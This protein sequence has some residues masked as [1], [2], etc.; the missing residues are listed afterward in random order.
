VCRASYS[1]RQAPAIG[2]Y[3]SEAQAAA[4]GGQSDATEGDIITEPAKGHHELF[5]QVGLAA[6]LGDDEAPARGRDLEGS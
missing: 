3:D 2:S 4:V 6:G 1:K 5:G